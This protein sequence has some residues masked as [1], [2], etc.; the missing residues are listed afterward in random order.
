MIASV[1]EFVERDRVILLQVPLSLPKRFLTQQFQKILNQHHD[2]HR[3][4]RTNR[5]STAKYPITGHVDTDAL[6]KCLRVYDMKVANLKMCLWE[7]AQEC[8]VARTIQFVKNDSTETQEEISDKKLILANTVSR[9]LKRAEK[10]VASVSCGKFP[11]NRQI[12]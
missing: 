1:E 8:K 12:R 5:I 7:I 9:L 3:G 11:V 6:E 4:I 2:E 10:I